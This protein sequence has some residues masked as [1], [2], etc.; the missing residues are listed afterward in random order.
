MLVEELDV[1]VVDAFC[2]LLADLMRRPTLNHVQTSPSVLSLSARR[3]TD[4]E[5]ILH[6]SLKV[7][8]FHMVGQGGRDL[9]VR[10][11]SPPPASDTKIKAIVCMA[12]MFTKIKR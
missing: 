10:D 4:K 8:L 11:V 3:G 9:P 5:I 12:T 7:V 6:L 2:N 1:A